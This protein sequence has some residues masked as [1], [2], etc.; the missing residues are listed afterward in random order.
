MQN[1]TTAITALEHIAN[2]F[3]KS[4]ITV[5]A[6]V[7]LTALLLLGFGIAMLGYVVHKLR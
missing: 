2:I 7:C 6:L 1:I 3:N 4:P 5:V